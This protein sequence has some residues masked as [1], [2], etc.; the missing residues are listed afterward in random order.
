MNEVT[1]VRVGQ[2]GGYNEYFLLLHAMETGISSGTM[3]RL[4]QNKIITGKE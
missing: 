1:R 4:T 2:G 3:D